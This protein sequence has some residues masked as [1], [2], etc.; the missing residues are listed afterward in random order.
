[1]IKILFIQTGSGF[2]YPNYHIKQQLSKHFPGCEIMEL[3]V[4]AI[5]KRDYWFLFC[6]LL[7]MIK[8]NIV[9]Q[10]FGRK[11]LFRYRLHFLGTTFIFKKLSKVAL[12]QIG[13]DNYDFIFQTQSLCDCSNKKGIPT[14]IY[15]DH[16]NLNNLNYQ[17]IKRSE[18]LHSAEYI[19]LEKQAYE[20]AELIFVMSANIKDSLVN[21]YK[22]D[23]RKIKIVFVGTNTQISQ[24]V[25][26]DKYKNENIL[27]VGKDWKR[28]GGPLLVEAFKI[29]QDSIPTAK[30]TI[31][32]CKPKI[33][34]KNC[35]VFGELSL[36]K[37][38]EI[39]NQ[40][41]VFCMP[42]LRE[43]FGIVFLEAMFNRLPVVT[44]AVGATPYIVRNNYNGYLLNPN[45]SE[46][47]K[48]LIELISNPATCEQFG[49]NSYEI[50][51]KT[52]T[53]ENVGELI[54]HYIS[55]ESYHLGREFEK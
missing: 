54:E 8:E 1:M 5:L 42:T 28:K 19:Q 13:K 44:N 50:A 46:Y 22:I 20:N 4:L 36:E 3:D 10:L 39:Y 17:F 38:G 27:F 34:L 55:K 52:Y 11:N 6:N 18:F 23:E 16:T 45:A 24:K 47:A 14:Y 43:P 51:S 21:Q 29:V 40:A 49:A 41:S 9:D 12:D 53:W 25:N 32:G 35:F 31:I 26:P 15:T 7:Y 33:K 30:L 37:V 2:R 48:A